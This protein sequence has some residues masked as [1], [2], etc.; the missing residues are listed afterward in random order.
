M[1][2]TLISKAHST[3]KRMLSNVYSKS[4]IH[5]SPHVAALAQT[6]L[7]DRLLPL[8][9][10]SASARTPLDVYSVVNATAMDFIT[11][12]LFGLPNST[13]S[14]KEEANRDEWIR[15]YQSRRPYM[16]WVGELPNL[17]RFLATIGVRVVPSW[18]D[19]ANRDI[20]AFCM[21]MCNAADKTVERDRQSGEDALDGEEP[22]VYKQLKQAMDKE[23]SKAEGPRKTSDPDR[24]RMEIASEMLDHLGTT[25]TYLFWELSRNPAIQHEL[26]HELQSLSPPLTFPTPKPNLPPPKIL[27]S[28]PFL[29]A[30]IMETLRLHPALPG[31]Q[32]RITPPNATIGPYTNLP[33]NV[34]VSAQA[35]SLH[36]N[37]EVFPEPEEWRP[38]RWLDE[39]AGEKH[40]WFWAFGSGGRMCVG[41]NFAM[42]EMKL[43]VAA[44]YT[45][46][47]SDIVDDSGIEQ[48]DGYTC[49]P[50]G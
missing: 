15:L 1:F 48:D 39:D 50:K 44:V 19:A 24:Q 35:Y 8:I 23:N 18:V 9:S 45:N 16:F 13:N 49:G 17:Q 10:R 20:E 26:R 46:F 3:R 5:A 42:Y 12:Y 31:G 25:L 47:S 27:D 41:S 30:C 37:T 32:P 29:Q 4:H 28:L 43:V 14:F 11:A 22:V 34:R 33:A 38:R 2:S 7:H 6:V 36:R 40:R 21:N